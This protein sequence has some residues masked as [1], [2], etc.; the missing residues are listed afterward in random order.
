MVASLLSL[1]SLERYVLQ[2]LP[3]LQAEQRIQEI[4]VG[5][6]G[7]QKRR[8]RSVRV[9]PIRDAVRTAQRRLIKHDVTISWLD[10]QLNNKHH[11]PCS[12]DPYPTPSTAVPIPPQPQ[13]F[14]LVFLLFFFS[15]SS[16]THQ[17]VHVNTSVSPP[18]SEE[19]RDIGLLL[20]M[21]FSGAE[22]EAHPTP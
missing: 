6:A 16:G 14:P 9:R 4:A 13:N 18:H 5:P 21:R 3:R 12:H 22:T 2:F 20:L 15:F 7:R 11:R 1:F 17:T 10:V 19:A 8:V